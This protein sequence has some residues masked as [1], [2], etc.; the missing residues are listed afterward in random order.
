M[1][2]EVVGVAHGAVFEGWDVEIACDGDFGLAFFPEGI[3]V[4]R[5]LL[6]LSLTDGGPLVDWVR[7][8]AFERR[9]QFLPEDVDFVFQVDEEDICVAG[10]SPRV[11]AHARVAVVSVEDLLLRP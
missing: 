1:D 8:V 11:A 5:D 10:R 7:G 4:R 3:S 6:R 9:V 2:V